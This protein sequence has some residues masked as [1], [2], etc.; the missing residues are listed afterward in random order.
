[1]AMHVCMLAT[2][3]N[4]IITPLDFAKK[5]TIASLLEGVLDSSSL[6]VY[7]IPNIEATGDLAGFPPFILH[8][9][10]ERGEQPRDRWNVS[11][12]LV[13]KK[14]LS[15]ESLESAFKHIGERHDALRLTIVREAN[16]WRGVVMDTPQK[17]LAFRT[18]LLSDL[19]RGERDNAMQEVA[20]DCQKNV[21]LSC[22]PIAHMVLFDSGESQPQ[23]LYFVVHH[24]M[25]DVISWKNFWFEFELAYLTLESGGRPST[26]V[27]AVSFKTWTHTLKQ[28]ASSDVSVANVGKWLQQDWQA[29]SE[30][31]RDF[32]SDWTA[33]TNSSADVV[34]FALSES[35]T[36]ALLRIGSHGV[37]LQIVLIGALA[38]CLSNWQNNRLVFFDRLVHGRNVALQGCELSRTIGC[39]VSYAPTLLTFD[40]ALPVSA[41]ISDI[42]RQMETVDELGTNIELFRYYGLDEQALFETTQL[43]QAKVLLN[44]RGNIDAVFDQSSLFCQPYHI[45]NLDHAP[46][47]LRRYPLAI[48]VDLVE[49][50]LTVRWV[51][52]TRLHRKSTI[53]RLGHEFKKFMVSIVNTELP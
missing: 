49:R 24:L 40:S 4:I 52:S 8:F 14:R 53:E 2:E 36:Q 48:S 21:N 26:P 3:Q 12:M 22:G 50:R 29:T 30:I 31:P 35:E 46:D 7:N 38:E 37:D 10:T 51:F 9:L 17:T 42:A 5:P 16:T 1:M 33:N 43:P 32:D 15:P 39:L 11:R 25:M 28:I 6:K 19:P 18:V 20:A 27:P 41:L 13:A 34:T 23:K 45:A 44:Y 47:G